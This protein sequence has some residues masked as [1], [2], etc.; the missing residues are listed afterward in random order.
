[1]R[2]NINEVMDN[3]L[4]DYKTMAVSAIKDA[5][6]K[7]QQDII[8][9]AK[10]Y[11]Q[12]YYDSYDP[13]YY[14]RKYNLKHAITPVFKNKSNKKTISFEIGVEYLPSKLQGKYPGVRDA[15]F[16][17]DNFIIGEHGGAQRDFNATYTLMPDFI[18]NK[19]KNDLDRYVSDSLF[20]VIMS[21]L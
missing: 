3:V 5:A 12:F 20:N 17:L 10:R 2:S 21:K 19:L 13:D 6:H 16:I 8:K 15:T 7:G 11:L 1:M 18:E 9:E 4:K 14:I